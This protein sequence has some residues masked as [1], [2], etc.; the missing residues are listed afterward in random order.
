M[1]FLSHIKPFPP[2]SKPAISS[3]GGKK[4]GGFHSKKL[5][6]NLKHHN[7]SLYL[8]SGPPDVREVDGEPDDGEEEVQVAAPRLTLILNCILQ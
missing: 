4:R 1:L 3:S 6:Q 7:I 5:K 2:F 8:I